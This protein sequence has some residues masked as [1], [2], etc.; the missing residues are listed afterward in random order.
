MV[1][2]LWSPRN[3]AHSGTTWPI[4]EHIEFPA[5]LLDYFLVTK[6][7]SITGKPWSDAT[8][9]CTTASSTLFCLFEQKERDEGSYSAC[10]SWPYRCLIMFTCQGNLSLCGTFL[11]RLLSPNGSKPLSEQTNKKIN[12]N[13]T[14]NFKKII[15]ANV[16]FSTQY[17]IREFQASWRE[18]GK[19]LEW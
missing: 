18:R 3:L 11:I 9:P 19:V 5:K 10:R 6:A 14:Q 15:V 16:F 7:T 8:C 17:Q 13:P 1:S 2:D 4:S 12:K